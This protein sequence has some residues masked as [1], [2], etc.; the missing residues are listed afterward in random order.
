MKN[1]KK[2]IYFKK[3]KK[4]N[5]P[6]GNVLMCYKEKILD[7]KIKIKEI[8]FTEIKYNKVK[9]WIKHNKISCNLI[10]PIGKVKFLFLSKKNKKKKSLSEKKIIKKYM[11][12]QILGLLL[13]DY[14]NQKV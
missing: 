4:F 10:V 6:K 5:N 9:G 12:P 1:L 2:N 8:Y 3:L 13:E 11:C 7:Q 14:Q